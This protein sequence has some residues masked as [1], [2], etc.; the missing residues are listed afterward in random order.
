MSDCKKHDYTL[1]GSDFGQCP[2]CKLEAENKRLKEE[3]AKRPDFNKPKSFDIDELFE[4][5]CE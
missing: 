2:L 3:L 5:E 1:V 4:K